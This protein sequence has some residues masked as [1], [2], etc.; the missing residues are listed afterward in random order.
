M[1]SRLAGD[2]VAGTGAAQPR[3]RGCV[4]G[5]NML[6]Q[7]RLAAKVSTAD[8]RQT[9]RHAAAHLSRGTAGR[10]GRGRRDFLAEESTVVGNLDGFQDWGKIGAA[11][12]VP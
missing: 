6:P 12:F 10:C 8:H 1:G 11:Q 4:V 9:V 7:S 5:G 3:A 2:A